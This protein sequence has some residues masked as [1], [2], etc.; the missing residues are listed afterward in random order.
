M[1]AKLLHLSLI[2]L[3][4]SFPACAG[5][6]SIDF[7]PPPAVGSPGDTLIFQGSLG[8]LTSD[9]GYDAFLNS[10]SITLA[11]PLDWGIDATPFL[12]NAPLI[13]ADGESSGPFEFFMLT[14]PD[15]LA[16][17][18]YD[19]EFAV[20]GGEAPDSEVLLGSSGFRVEVAG[21]PAAV[22][23]PS[24]LLLAAIGL[25]GL[26]LPRLWKRRGPAIRH[27]N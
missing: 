25:G 18:Y 14:I 8:T 17:G 13:L 11:G 2:A 15:G 9:L 6:I 16:S 19:G 21:S 4:Y 5:S 12:I 20:L 23:E 3:L 26:L 10:L 22:P 1:K 7:A 24:S 27:L